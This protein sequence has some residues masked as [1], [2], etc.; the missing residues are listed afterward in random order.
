M[1]QKARVLIV[2]DHPVLRQGLARL[3]AQQ[4][5]L[6]VVGEAEGVGEARRLCETTH[7]DLM[8]IDMSLKEGHGLD[9]IKDLKA[10][11]SMA[12]ML[13]VSMHEEAAYAERALRA[14][15]HGYIPK[16]EAVEEIV[17]ALRRVRAGE[18]YLNQRMTARLLHG[19]VGG[20][21]SPGA[22][23]EDLLSDRELQ[24]FELL[25]QGFSSREISE[26][27]SVSIKTIDTYREHIKEKLHLRS[28]NEL[29]LRAV[30]WAH[31]P[32]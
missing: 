3:I 6:E 22:S 5:D 8:V 19:I 1:Q 7:P 9:L 4:P 10:A 23:P 21:S 30:L 25:G 17:Q 18:V 11:G 2:D 15:A 29:V 32:R 27:L 14:G 12:R 24:V 16:S 31:E 26:K 20:E 13:V 28:A